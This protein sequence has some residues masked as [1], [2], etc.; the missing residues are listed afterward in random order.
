MLGEKRKVIQYIREGKAAYQSQLGLT[1]ANIRYKDWTIRVDEVNLWLQWIWMDKG[2]AQH[3]RTWK[4]SSH[5]TTTEIVQTAFAAALM[6]EEHEMRERFK[7]KGQPIFIAHIDVDERASLLA[8]P[9]Y[10]YDKRKEA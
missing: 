7:Y 4:L 1:L 8:D 9:N 6:A 5:M 3:G 2:E 10:I